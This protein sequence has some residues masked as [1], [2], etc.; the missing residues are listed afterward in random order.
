MIANADK[1]AFAVFYNRMFPGLFHLSYKM[2]NSKSEAEDIVA[3]T[4]VKFWKSRHQFTSLPETAAWL[5]RTTRNATL[6]LLKH[7][8]VKSRK[9]S[10]VAA[11]SYP[12]EEFSVAD[13]YAELLQ[14]IYHQIE[15][16]PPRGKEIFKL[17]YL[18]GF[19]NEEI[20]QKLGI[21]NQ[22]V[23]DHLARSLKTLRMEIIKKENLFSFFL[24]FINTK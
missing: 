10:E 16:L 8:Q 4:F 3:D 17:R 19:S 9:E 5:R 18:G 11:I 1:Q 20:A 14:E 22:S 13:M 12:Q 6:D 21:N 15:Q 2:L 7:Q 24:V 23:R